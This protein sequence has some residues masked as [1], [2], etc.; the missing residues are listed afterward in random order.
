MAILARHRPS[1][2]ARQLFDAHQRVS[3]AWADPTASC[4]CF[5]PAIPAVQEQWLMPYRVAPCGK[6]GAGASRLAR[7]EYCGLPAL[8]VDADTADLPR[9][10]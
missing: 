1:P 8:A 9:L 7:H 2:P 6:L 5:N 4:D 10:F 3:T